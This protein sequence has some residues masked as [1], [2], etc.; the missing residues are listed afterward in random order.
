VTSS[1]RVSRGGGPRLNW[2]DGRVAEKKAQTVR[3]GRVRLARDLVERIFALL[4]PLDQPRPFAEQVE[5]LSRAAA[6]LGIGRAGTDGGAMAPDGEAGLDRLRDALED[7]AGALE[8]LGRGEARW[9]WA[10][11]AAGVESLA[12]E[13]PAP[14]APPPPGAVRVATGDEVAGAR[15]AHM[16]LAD[17]AEGSF[18]A[19]DAAEAFLEIRPGVPPDEASRRVF[20]REMLRFLRV[21]GSAESG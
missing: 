9:S 13:L 10:A 17:L 7:Q 19:R 18:P 14:P 4:A 6:D 15:V 11:F 12:T 20:S 1:P 21:I 16:I 2:L 3:A 5:R 8:R